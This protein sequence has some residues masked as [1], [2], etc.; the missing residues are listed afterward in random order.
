M[1]FI[2]KKTMKIIKKD[3]ESIIE[4]LVTTSKEIFIDDVLETE[5]DYYLSVDI[6]EPLEKID[7]TT[8][9]VGSIDDDWKELLKQIENKDRIFTA[10]D[11]ERVA[12][13]I[14]YLSYK[15]MI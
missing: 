11:F 3:F 8:I 7:S 12:N 1:N 10:V 4:K 6:S 2:V 15:K 13:I 9:L 5:F 14:K